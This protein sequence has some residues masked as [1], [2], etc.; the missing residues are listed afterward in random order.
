MTAP[1]PLCTTTI[2]WIFSFATRRSSDLT[3]LVVVSDDD[4]PVFDCETL[5]T[6]TFGTT[7]PSCTN[8]TDVSVPSATDNCNGSRSEEGTRSD[9]AVMTAPW[10][11]GTTTITWTF[12]DAASNQTQCTQLVVVSDDDAP[13]FDCETL[14]TQTFGTTAPSCTN[15]TDVSVPSAT[16]NCNGSVAGVGTRSDLAVMTAP[17]PLGTTTITW[18]FTDAAS[19]QTQCTQLVVV[20]HDYAPVFDCETLT[21]Q[22]FGTTAPSCTND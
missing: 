20:L 10:P 4:A 5:T 18:T 3:Q 16:D 15:D 2:T 9:L 21:T 13:V 1:W 6:Q 7:A 17:W 8:D 14:T 11:L 22:T 19:N 12:T